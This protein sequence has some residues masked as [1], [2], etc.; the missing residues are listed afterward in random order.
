[1][2]E[3]HKNSKLLRTQRIQRLQ[4]NATVRGKSK[5]K[6]II[7]TKINNPHLSLKEIAK[8]LHCSYAHAR[9]VWSKYQ[10][11]ML[12]NRGEPSPPYSVHGS[13]REGVVPSGWL[14]DCPL[15][16]SKNRN[17]QKV[18]KGS[19][20]TMVF[21]KSGK[22]MVYAYYDGWEQ[23]AREFLNSFWDSDRTEL[24]IS[25]LEDRGV[26]SIALH[27]PKIPKNFKVRI[28]GIG[29]LQTD[30]TPYP[31]GTTEFEFDPELLKRM[32]S[33]EKCLN[34]FISYIG[35]LQQQNILALQT[36]AQMM[37]QNTEALRQFTEF[38]KGL[39]QPKPLKRDRDSSMVV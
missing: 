3:D 11:G 5:K 12:Q 23:E 20:T 24:F 34:K 2:T 30:T 25:Y 37:K 14:K 33:I 1:M 8:I 38:M 15:D 21:H 4:S 26:P 32:D 35:K 13:W 18:W 28:R 31:D 9:R 22:V 7:R 6:Q 27:T 19:K 16:L 39:S 10:K 29:T 17:G 36:N